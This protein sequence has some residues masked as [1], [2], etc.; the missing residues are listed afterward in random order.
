MRTVMGFRRV[1]GCFEPGISWFTT[2]CL[3]APLQT[4]LSAA[5]IESRICWEARQTCCVRCNVRRL[6]VVDTSAS[7]SL[8]ADNLRA[9]LRLC[10]MVETLTLSRGCGVTP[11]DV[12]A[13]SRVCRETLGKL[14]TVEIR[15]AKLGVVRE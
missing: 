2:R 5:M 1:I 10:P 15:K 12:T 3:T 14:N 6:S 11:N 9:L 8:Q 7:S 4:R 13:L